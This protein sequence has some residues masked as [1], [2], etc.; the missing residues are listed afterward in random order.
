MGHMIGIG[1]I[2]LISQLNSIFFYVI[3]KEV[4]KVIVLI[5]L[6]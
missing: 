3:L 6:F 5:K 1:E 4:L 2:D